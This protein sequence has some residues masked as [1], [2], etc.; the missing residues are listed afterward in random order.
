MV[1]GRLTLIG[2]SLTVALISNIMGTEGLTELVP[3]SG[4]NYC[5]TQV[6]L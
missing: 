2:K 5:I 3:F 1:E 6:S 4:T